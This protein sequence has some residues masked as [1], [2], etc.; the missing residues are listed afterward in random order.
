MTVKLHLDPQLERMLQA[1]A[2]KMGLLLEAYLLQL[3]ENQL[4]ARLKASQPK[5]VRRMPGL[6]QG[7]VGS[8]FFEPLPPEE[9]AAWGS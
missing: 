7:K 5:P 4:E 1:E 2:A 9:L 6:L 8:A 3:I